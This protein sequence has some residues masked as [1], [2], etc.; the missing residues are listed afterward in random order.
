MS[1]NRLIAGRFGL[2]ERIGQGSMGEVFRGLDAQSGALV[3]IK[4]LKQSLVQNDPEIAQRFER[5][6]EALRRL[7]HPSIVEVLLSTVEDG[8]H[9]IVMEYV[10]GGSLDR[11]LK[12]QKQLP[13]ARVLEIG[14]DLSD[15]LIRAHRLHIIHRDIKPQN[16]LLAEDGTPRLTDFGVAH[17]DDLSS[18]T[19]SGALV[20]TLPYLSPEAWRFEEPD[21]RTDIWAF[22]VMLYEMLAGRRPFLGDTVSK[23]KEAILRHPPPDV[24]Q[25]CADAPAS[26]SDLIAQML[27][28]DPLRRIETMRR[29]GLELERIARSIS[30]SAVAVAPPSDPR[31]P[32]PDTAPTAALA[33]SEV[34]L[35][36]SST[37]VGYTVRLRSGLEGAVSRTQ[38]FNLPFDLTALPRRR[39]DVADWVKQARIRRLR[40]NEE[41]KLAREFGATLFE[42]L[43]SGTVLEAFRASRSAL[44]PSE[45]LRLRLRLPPDLASIP[46]EL[47]YD[48]RDEQFLALTH[49]LALLRYPELPVRLAPLK[50]DGPLRVVV[51]LASPAGGDYPPIRL[52]RELHRIESVLRN[53]R[54]QGRIALDVIRG[55]GTLDQLRARLRAPEAVHVLHV[56]CHGDL[57][58]ARGGVLIFE[59][60]DGAAEPIG[61]DHLRTLLQ[62]RAPQLVLLNACLGATPADDDPF[63]SVGAALLRGGVPAVIAMQFE[64]AEDAAV[65][66][67]RVFYAELA[68]GAPVDLALTEAR[69]DLSGRYPQRLDWAIPVLFLR[70]ET[71]ALFELAA[72]ASSTNLSREAGAP[73]P[74]PRAPTPH[75][76]IVELKTLRRLWHLALTACT[77]NDWERAAE[78]LQQ[79]A[80]VNPAYEDVQAQLAEARRRL[81]LPPLYRQA[82]AQ[83]ADDH[84]QAALEALDAL[85]REQP[86]YP[87]AQGVRAWAEQRRRREQRFADARAA[88]ERADWAAAST[89]LEA[90]LAEQPDDAEAH[91][92][93][94]RVRE[95]YQAASARERQ[96]QADARR[97][98]HLLSGGTSRATRDPRAR[99]GA[100]LAHIESGEFAE[101]LDMLEEL[102]MRQHDQHAAELA[103]SLIER[104]DVPLPLRLRAARLAG[105]AEDPRAGVF[106][107]E[108]AWRLFPAGRYVIGALRDPFGSA[109]PNP[110]RVTLEEFQI[111]RYPV[112]VRQFLRFWEDRDGYANQRW[113]T[114][115]GWAWKQGHGVKQPYRWGEPGWMA[116]NQPVA[117]IAWYEAVA[118][119][120]WLTQRRRDARWLRGNQVIRLPSEAEWEVAATW[121][122]RTRQQRP[123]RPPEGE[124]WQNVV[125]ASMGRAS[126]VG[127]FPE[128]ASPSGVF[129]MAGNL[130]EWCASRYAD[131]PQEATRLQVDFASNV[132]GP[133]VRGGAYNIRNMLSGWGA[134]NWYFP[135][136]H[137]YFT[138]FRV[139][140]TSK[141]FWGRG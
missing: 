75:E 108:P 128:G 88:H 15:A 49:D 132:E 139:V 78:L 111:A 81:A 102:L 38:P 140:L 119:C 89:A 61:A 107:M 46:W 7:N 52:D 95:E 21:E 65:E 131:Y 127:L 42:R 80:D 24:R 113:W 77:L 14:I 4:A 56:L 3:A 93:L 43:F 137:Q 124:L 58:E 45:R 104:A 138:G 22:G 141:G 135:S 33:A 129:D 126:P 91:A 31:P 23:I 54:A 47:L 50:V 79:V 86:D 63:S 125:E 73:A 90:L 66:L 67:A 101:A 97:K 76:K 27:E 130:W 13:L 18:I 92:L 114:P 44:P 40:A 136:L 94:A 48:P 53:A 10:G 96:F 85:E 12:Q 69:L 74:M 98:H 6:G 55:H 36:I 84:W 57:D 26:L 122:P 64:L 117:G 116:L 118:F 82:L 100:P 32:E 11:L 133:V 110:Q 106:E 25:F 70:A 103:A 35:T 41:L 17:M 71:G 120:N 60:A 62:R 87:D 109:A 105:Q 8:Q 1:T 37:A 5:E 39:H 134:R 2:G 123:W 99:Y 20:G 115:Q 9:Y 19:Q 72:P 28:K 112:T 59:D 121:D 29:I 83:R 68:A 34:D 51:V 16:V 30:P